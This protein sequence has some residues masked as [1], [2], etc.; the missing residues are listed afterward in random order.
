MV[1]TAIQ[2]SPPTIKN[3]LQL[4]IKMDPLDRIRNGFANGYTTHS[5]F[6]VACDSRHEPSMIPEALKFATLQ[7]KMAPI[8]PHT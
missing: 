1:I 7:K 6:H 8:P 3:H 4:Y 5:H 2:N